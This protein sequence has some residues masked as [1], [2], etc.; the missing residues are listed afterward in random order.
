MAKWDEELA[1]DEDLE[2]D[3]EFSNE[4]E[5]H[6]LEYVGE[7]HWNEMSFHKYTETSTTWHYDFYSQGNW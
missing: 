1:V 3:P 4:I 2:D 6:P 5:Y 7:I